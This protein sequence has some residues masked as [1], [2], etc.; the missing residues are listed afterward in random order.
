MKA[1]Q[2]HQVEEFVMTTGQQVVYPLSDIN[3]YQV[4]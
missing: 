1:G 4:I 3:A 2:R